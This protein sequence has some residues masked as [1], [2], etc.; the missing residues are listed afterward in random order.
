M[1]VVGPT[2]QL[3][4]SVVKGLQYRSGDFCSGRNEF[5]T[6]IV[7]DTCAQLA[8]GKFKQ[9]VNKDSLQIGNLALELFVDSSNTLLVLCLGRTC[10]DSL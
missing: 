6:H 9:L 8:G 7:L 3:N 5:R 4:G 2:A 10:L 1:L